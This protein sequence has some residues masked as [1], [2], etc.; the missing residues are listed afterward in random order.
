M[1]AV[2]GVAGVEGGQGSPRWVT[3]AKGA[4]KE[5]PGKSPVAEESRLVAGRRD[6][7]TK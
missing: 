4:E 3:W 2:D 5:V 6:C 7:H 1:E